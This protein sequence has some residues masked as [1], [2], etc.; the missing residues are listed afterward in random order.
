MADTSIFLRKIGVIHSPYL[1]NAPTQPIEVESDESEYIIEIDEEYTDGLADLT[2]FKYIYVIFYLHR[3]K[4]DDS[5]INL[6]AYPPWLERG[7]GLFSSRSPVRPNPIGLSVVKIKKIEKNK[8]YVYGIDALDG[9]PLLDI[10]PYFKD[11]DSK[12]DANNGWIKSERL[13]DE[14]INYQKR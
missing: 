7:V 4:Q 1:D 11:V 6:T 10:K 3:Y 2:D 9:T 12:S 8:I 5:N 13:R 14:L